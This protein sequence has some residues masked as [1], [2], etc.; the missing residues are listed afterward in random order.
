MKYRSLEH[1]KYELLEAMKCDIDIFFNVPIETDY[2]K[3]YSAG[4]IS[5]SAGVLVVKAHYA[6]DGPSGPHL[7]RRRICG[8]RCSTTRCANL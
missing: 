3:L 6:W 8:D 4:D 1:W 7:T 2:V 5:P